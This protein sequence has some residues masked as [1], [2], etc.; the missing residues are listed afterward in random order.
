MRF[1]RRS[2]KTE[3]GLNLAL[4]YSVV[5]FLIFLLINMLAFAE[6]GTLILE[7]YFNSY[8]FLIWLHLF[9]VDALQWMSFNLRLQLSFYLEC[10]I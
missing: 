10:H 5:I 8:I 2:K 3:N 4:A 7:C 1:S 6:G 9:T